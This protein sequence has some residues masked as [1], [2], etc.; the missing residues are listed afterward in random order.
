VAPVFGSPALALLAAFSLL[1]GYR[2]FGVIAG[3]GSR[4]WAVVFAAVSVPAAAALT[5]RPGG[6]GHGRSVIEQLVVLAAAAGGLATAV[7]LVGHGR[8]L[9]DAVGIADLA[10]AA[11]ALGALAAG[12]RGRYRGHGAP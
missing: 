7:A 9:T 10:L 6:G 1:E 11:A 8:W 4:P 3:S 5:R 12:E 2:W